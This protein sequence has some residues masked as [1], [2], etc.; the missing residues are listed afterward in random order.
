MRAR[1]L[2]DGTRARMHLGSGDFPCR[3]YFIGGEKDLPP[4]GRALAQLR[5]DKPVFAFVGDR[6]IVRFTYDVTAKSGPMAGKRMK[7]DEA[8]LY[9]VKDGKIV[10][11]EFF[12][13]MG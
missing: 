4:G 3:V 7:L 9:A 11:E 8:A 2:R 12:Y 10:Q 6:F 13:H 5:F 1:S